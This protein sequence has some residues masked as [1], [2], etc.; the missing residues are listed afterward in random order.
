MWDQSVFFATTKICG[1]HLDVM[2]LFYFLRVNMTQA[3]CDTTFGSVTLGKW[4]VRL[5]SDLVQST[6]GYESNLAQEAELE[7]K[8]VSLIGNPIYRHSRTL[9]AYGEI[10][11]THHL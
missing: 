4:R 3:Q 1:V 2:N 7:L 11:K 9:R 5:E 10:E 8:I 6:L